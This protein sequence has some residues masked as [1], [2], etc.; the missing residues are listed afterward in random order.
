MFDCPLQSH[1]S[2]TTTSRTV[3]ALF[4]VMTISR[5]VGLAFIGASFTDHFPSRSAVSDTIRPAKTTVTFS[6][7]PPSPTPPPPDRAGA[8]YDP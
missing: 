6:R 3:M 8:P 5:A 7:V 2:P 1:T 4:P